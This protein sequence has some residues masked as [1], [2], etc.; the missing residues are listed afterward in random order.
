MQHPSTSE[1]VLSIMRKFAHKVQKRELSIHPKVC[2]R[3]GGNH[4][5]KYHVAASKAMLSDG[6][7]AIQSFAR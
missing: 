6:A 3:A 2:A 4:H 1:K 5:A 7:R